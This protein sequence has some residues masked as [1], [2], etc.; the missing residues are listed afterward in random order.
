MDKKLQTLDTL[1]EIVSELDCGEFHFFV[2]EY[3]G[4][5]YLQIFFEA[6]DV[7]TGEM[8]LQYTRKWTLQYTMCNTEVVRTAFKAAEAAIIHELQEKFTYRGA[9][10]YDPHMDVE[11]L[12]DIIKHN[13]MQD[14]RVAITV[15][16]SK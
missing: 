10:V 4:S 11:K 8:Q 5:P 1:D 9:R 12:V 13:N 7:N 16:N 2:D 14:T 6:P 15:N 3:N